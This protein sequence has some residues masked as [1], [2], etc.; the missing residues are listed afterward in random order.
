M[1]GAYINCWVNFA[2]EEGAEVLARHYV[3]KAGRVVTKVDEVFWVEREDYEGEESLQ[4]F[5]EA[6]EEGVSVVL[7]LYPPDEAN[8]FSEV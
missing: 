1:A 6:S 4:Y 7:H 8:G 2:L 3:E 5:D